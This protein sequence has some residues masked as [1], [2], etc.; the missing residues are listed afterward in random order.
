[1]ILCG[2]GKDDNEISGS[3]SENHYK[4]ASVRVRNDRLLSLWYRSRAD[5]S[6]NK[7]RVYTKMIARLST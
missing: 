1:M 5:V 2:N 3:A 4:R 6:W 7:V